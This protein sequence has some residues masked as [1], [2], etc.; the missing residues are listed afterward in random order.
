MKFFVLLWGCPRFSVVQVQGLGVQGLR[1][2]RGLGI[3]PVLQGGREGCSFPG[4]K[5][6]GVFFSE[7]RRR[8][9]FSTP[10]KGVSEREVFAFR[11]EGCVCVSPSLRGVLVEG[12]RGEGS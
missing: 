12:G 8:G 11:S 9:S 5:G 2:F 4:T 3:V 1:G 7:M 6:G 10:K